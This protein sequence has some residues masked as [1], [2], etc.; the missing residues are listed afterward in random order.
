VRLADRR[1]GLLLV[2][3]D[4]AP[5]ARPSMTHSQ[6]RLR[7]C[8]IRVRLGSHGSREPSRV[9]P[10]KQTSKRQSLCRRRAISGLMQRSIERALFEVPPA[11]RR[12]RPN[13]LV[14][15]PA[16]KLR[17]GAMRKRQRP[18][19]DCNGDRMSVGGQNRQYS[20]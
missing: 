18:R 15:V 6:Q 9:F 8:R 11:V 16:S 17:P 2:R 3:P 12:H 14:E 4:H 1:G 19:G 5:K 13:F 7:E 20:D 10:R